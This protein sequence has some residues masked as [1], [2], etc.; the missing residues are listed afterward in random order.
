MFPVHT[1]ERLD[2]ATVDRLVSMNE[3]FR[4][5]VKDVHDIA[6]VGR[7]WD[8]FDKPL[9]PD[10]YDDYVRSTSVSLLIDRN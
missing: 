4:S 6:S 10:E 9:T 2:W 5:F 1:R 7:V 3:D 8:S